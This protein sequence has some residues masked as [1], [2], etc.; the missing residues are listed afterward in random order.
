MN[1]KQR[2]LD[3]LKINPNATN[4]QIARKLKISG[5]S[6]AYHLANLKRD[7]YI[8]KGDRWIVVKKSE[9]NHQPV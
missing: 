2:I 7:G 4:P 5:S 6:V 8:L 3:Y 9:D 1:T